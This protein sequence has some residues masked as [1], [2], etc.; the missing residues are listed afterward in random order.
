MK[1]EVILTAKTVE[2]AMRLARAQYGSADNELSFE[3]L[4]M[5]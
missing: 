1:N 3:I 5:P 4:E 2:E